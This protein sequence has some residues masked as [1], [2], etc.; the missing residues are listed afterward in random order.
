MAPFIKTEALSFTYH[1]PGEEALPALRDVS[2]QIEE[3]ELVALIGANGSGK[4]TLARLLTALLAPTSGTV[5]V[6]G[7][8]TRQPA[9]REAIHRSLGMVFQ[10]PED[11]VIATTVEEDVAFGPENLGLPSREIRTRVDAALREVDLWE[12][13]LRPPHLLSAGQVQRLALA[14]V[15]AMEPR[16]IIFDEATAMLDPSGRRFALEKMQQL[17]RRGVMV[18]FITHF[19]EEA[20][21]ADRVVVLDRGQV[22]LD[23]PPAT[24]FTSE[25]TLARLSLDLPPAA[26]LAASLRRVIPSLPQGLLTVEFSGPGVGGSFSAHSQYWARQR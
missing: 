25:T 8:D 5:R 22:A 18:I 1:R 2:L 20:V 14:G 26:R 24:V 10:F 6:G 21:Q 4:T 13:R 23:G 9:N 3:G 16:G 11:Q 15:L 19:M 7:L 12:Q 17:R